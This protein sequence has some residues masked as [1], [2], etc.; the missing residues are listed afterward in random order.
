MHLF[1][2]D[3]ADEAAD[4]GDVGVVQ[5]KQGKD[6]VGL[7]GRKKKGKYESYYLDE[8]NYATIA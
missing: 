5:A 3:D 2:G 4:A 1:Q 6:G 8:F 7:W